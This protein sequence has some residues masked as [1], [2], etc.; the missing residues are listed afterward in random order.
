MP[1][2]AAGTCG[3]TVAATS[4]MIAPPAMPEASRQ[5][6]NQDS[7]TGNA[8]AAKASVTSSIIARSTARFEKR[9][10]SGRPASAPSR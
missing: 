8:Q 7:E 3:S 10:A 9:R 4:T 6:K 1:L 5:T 2:R